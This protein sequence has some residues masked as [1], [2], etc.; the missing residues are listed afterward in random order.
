MDS[1]GEYM[2]R[3][4]VPIVEVLSGDNIGKLQGRL[5]IL[6][7]YCLSHNSQKAPYIGRILE[8]NGAL[9][10][11]LTDNIEALADLGDIRKVRLLGLG[12]N[13]IAQ[14]EEL[15]SGEDNFRDFIAI[16][17]ST[18]LSWQSDSLWVKMATKDCEIVATSHLRNLQELMWKVVSELYLKR[19]EATLEQAT[20]VGDDVQGL[21]SRIFAKRL[22]A[23]LH[24]LFLAQIYVL[25]LEYYISRVTE[26]KL[27]S[28]P[29]SIKEQ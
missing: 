8:I 29:I 20:I 22:P 4:I 28:P 14:L 16:C 27:P 3:E 6:H 11:L 5:H 25:L 1:I 10:G 7:S 2:E 9:Q 24:I 12:S 26:K 23:Q 18:L 19:D 15:L 21:L 17:F 13:A